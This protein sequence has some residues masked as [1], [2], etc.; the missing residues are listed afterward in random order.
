[1]NTISIILFVITFYF[2]VLRFLSNLKIFHIQLNSW[3]EGLAIK[4]TTLVV[5]ITW[6][7]WWYQ[8]AF[9]AIYHKI[10]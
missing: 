10:F 3:Y 2:T 8:I 5:M 9:W 1:M 7:M 6:V 4:Q